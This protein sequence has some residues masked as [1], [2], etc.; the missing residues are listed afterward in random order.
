MATFVLVHGAWHGAWCWE[1]LVGELESRGHEATAM[2]LPIDDPAATFETYADV[3]GAHVADEAGHDAIVVG[4]SMAGPTISLVPRRQRVRRLVYLCA[5]VPEPGVSV[6]QQ[7]ADEDILDHGYL[8]IRGEL[9]A[10]GFTR[11]ADAAAARQFMYADCDAADTQ[12]AIQRLRPQAQSPYVVPC[13]LTDFPD[14]PST[15]IACGEDRLVRPAWSRWVAEQRLDA[16]FIELPGSHSPFLSRPD[17]L[18]SVLDGLVT[19]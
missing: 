19:G 14:V 18:A 2:D 16:D 11:W 5:V 8:E 3:V 12:A 4:H 15:Y 9:V 13:P 6:A 17:H 10:D 1:R 7:L